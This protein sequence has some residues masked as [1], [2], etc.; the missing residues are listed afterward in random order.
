MPLF[1]TVGDGKVRQVVDNNLPEIGTEFNQ[2]RLQ[3]RKLSGMVIRRQFLSIRVHKR[4]NSRSLLELVTR[5][6]VQVLRCGLGFV[7]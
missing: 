7:P 4:R 6:L 3:D 5:T 2:V 1:V